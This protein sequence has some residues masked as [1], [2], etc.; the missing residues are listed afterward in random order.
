M[1]QPRLTSSISGE[2][3]RPVRNLCHDSCSRGKFS[4]SLKFVDDQ[5]VALDIKMSKWNFEQKSSKK[6]VN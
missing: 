6:E 5:S 3:H 4:S 2:M 1:L